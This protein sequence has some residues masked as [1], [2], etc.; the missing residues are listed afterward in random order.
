M[1][2]MLKIQLL[3]SFQKNCI[4]ALNKKVKD[5]FFGKVAKS[6]H[7][8]NDYF[9]F[10]KHW[11]W[12]NYVV[13]ELKLKSLKFCVRSDLKSKRKN[14]LPRKWFG[15]K[16]IFPCDCNIW[17]EGGLSSQNEG[18]NCTTN[19]SWR[20]IKSSA[21]FSFGWTEKVVV[22]LIAAITL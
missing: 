13:Q 5:L 8:C 2:K 4:I 7:W 17:R 18:I 10:M 6:A 20:I 15:R 3:K 22:F 21:F 1:F 19:F 11:I 12:V 14:M 16:S 9:H